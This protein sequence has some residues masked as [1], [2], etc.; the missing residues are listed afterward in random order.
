MTKMDLRPDVS[1][2][3]PGRTYRFY[4]GEPIYKFGDGL[5]YSKSVYEFSSTTELVRPGPFVAPNSEQ[6]QCGEDGPGDN[7][8]AKDRDYC[9]SIAFPI[10]I[11]LS[12][13]GPAGT[14]VVLLY[15]SPPGAGHNG[16]PLKQ[17]IDFKRVAV[18]GATVVDFSVEP[19]KQFKLTSIDEDGKTGSVFLPG[20]Y[21]LSVDDESQLTVEFTKS[22]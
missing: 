22:Q 21:T 2:G 1:S 12:H 19:C 16:V 6:L 14:E 7:C 20:V 15:M 5:S 4:T 11:S 18:K 13:E 10:E 3:Y 8:S 9:R 17:L